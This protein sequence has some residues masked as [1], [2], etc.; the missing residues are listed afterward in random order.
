MDLPRHVDI[1]VIGAGVIGCSVAWHL[2]ALGA[3]RSVLVLDRGPVGGGTSAQSSGILRTHYSVPQNVELARHSW[4]VFDRFAQVLDDPEAS[5]GLV[6]SGYLIVAPPGEKSQALD[7][8]L[9]AQ[10]AQGIEVHR[11]DAAQ[12][13]EHL[14]IAQFDDEELI[15]YEPQAGFADAYLTA[16]S[17]ARAARH[18]GVLVREGVAVQGL[19]IEGQR[20]A[21]VLTDQGPIATG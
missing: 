20:V 11:L 13:R 8:A 1:V 2:A 16:S 4:A 18:R 7:A 17:F 21:G 6:R 15:G 14:P 12:A 5:A 19:R 9:S 3:G 10:A